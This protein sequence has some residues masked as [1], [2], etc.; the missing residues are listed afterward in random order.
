MFNL[1]RKLM[2]LFTMSLSIWKNGLNMVFVDTGGWIAM[3]VK[4]DRYH[5]KVTTCRPTI[6]TAFYRFP[7]IWKFRKIAKNW[8]S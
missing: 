3:A 2:P 4:R 5:K 1:K 8:P 7:M 6:K